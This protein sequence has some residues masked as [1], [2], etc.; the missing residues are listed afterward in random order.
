MDSKS[1]LNDGVS[2]AIHV[3]YVVLDYIKMSPNSQ[4]LKSALLRTKKPR[5][6]KPTKIKNISWSEIVRSGK[7]K[8]EAPK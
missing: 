5:G 3:P 4:L 7:G 6:F 8:M 1:Q 2:A